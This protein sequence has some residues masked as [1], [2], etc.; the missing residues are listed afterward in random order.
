MYNK[1][2]DDESGEFLH[3]GDTVLSASHGLV[4]IAAMFPKTNQIG[5]VAVREKCALIPDKIMLGPP[6]LI[7]AHF[8]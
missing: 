8:I 6:A 1:L 3:V 2:V 5:I 4:K 7:V